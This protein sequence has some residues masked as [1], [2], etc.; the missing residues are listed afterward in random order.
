MLSQELP[1]TGEYIAGTSARPRAFDFPTR[2]DY[3]AGIAGDLRQL[4]IEP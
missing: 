4:E 3:L 2:I 1:G